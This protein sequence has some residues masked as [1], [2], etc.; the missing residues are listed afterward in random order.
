M[1]S[2]SNEFA[3]ISTSANLWLPS[4]QSSAIACK[5]TGSNRETNQHPVNVLHLINGEHFS[6]AERVQQ[7]LGKRLPEVQ[8]FPHFVCLKQGKFTEFSGLPPESMS[9]IC[10]SSRF[11]LS[12]VARIA[13]QAKSIGAD[14]IHAHTPRAAMI[15]NFVSR[16]CKL[17]WVY[18]VHSPAARDSTRSLINRINNLVEGYSLR[19][20]DHIITV[21]KSLRREMLLHGYGRKRVTAVANGVACQSPISTSNRLQ[22][23]SWRLGMIALVRPR[24]GIEVLFQALDKLRSRHNKIT[25]E[26]VGGFE[27]SEYEQ[28]VRA[29]VTELRLENVVQF[30]GFTNNVPAAIQRLDALVLPSL[31][32]EGMP[33]VVLEAMAM[34]VP[35]IATRVEGT[36]EVIRHGEEGL[37]AEPQDPQSLADQITAFTS[38]RQAWER[39]SHNAFAR[40]RERYSDIQ[41][42]TA[43]A[44]VY[45][46]VLGL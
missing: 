21:S 2:T 33:M 13:E 17:P 11:D 16:K 14:I 25:V 32:G 45:R 34:G 15:A 29:L 42:A 37:L 12:I 7:L 8:V 40:H 41:M 20:A 1:Q 31:F 4:N 19:R 6:G 27:T 30:T 22:Q 38:D 46:K 24:K 3:S 18:H 28:S 36:P 44:K 39:M 10:M 9:T 35:V 23:E 26:I 5:N 43:T